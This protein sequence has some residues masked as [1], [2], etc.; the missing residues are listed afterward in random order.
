[1]A[2]IDID[3][4]AIRTA[5]VDATVAFWNDVLGTTTAPRPDFGFPGAWLK[6]GQTMIHLYGGDAAKNADGIV[7]R[8]GAAVD[9]IALAAQGFDDM[10]NRIDGRGLDWREQVIE[11]LALWQI[12]VRDPNGVLVEMNFKT[13]GEPAG[14]QGP[15]GNRTYKPGNI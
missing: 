3:H 7:E 14:T 6:M 13:A 9:H 8:G 5:D 4:I 15:G 2:V 1:M 11:S 12:F 10:R